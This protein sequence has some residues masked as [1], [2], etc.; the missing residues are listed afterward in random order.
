MLV[1]RLLRRP[2]AILAAWAWRWRWRTAAQ[3]WSLTS[4]RG[5]A[6]VLFWSQ[7]MLDIE[8]FPFQS[9]SVMWCGGGCGL[10]WSWGTHTNPVGCKRQGP[11][12]RRSFRNAE[13]WD[14]CL[15]HFYGWWWIS[16]T[17]FW[18]LLTWYCWC[19]FMGKCSSFEPN[20]GHSGK[21]YPQSP[22]AKA[23]R[24]K[25]NWVAETD[26]GRFTRF[27][28]RLVGRWFC[29]GFDH[30]KNMDPQWR[31]IYF[32]ES[33][34]TVDE[35]KWTQVVRGVPIYLIAKVIRTRCFQSLALL[36]V[37]EN[38]LAMF[39]ASTLVERPASRDTSGLGGLPCQGQ[40]VMPTFEF[41]CLVTRYVSWALLFD[42]DKKAWRRW[43]CGTKQELMQNYPAALWIFVARCCSEQLFVFRAFLRKE[44]LHSL[45]RRRFLGLFLGKRVI[46]R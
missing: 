30:V 16:P 7:D 26:G 2:Y 43:Q 1:P 33:E 45:E 36:E 27:L 42:K 23:C 20:G 41:W 4:S 44:Y 11:C 3:G 39:V 9:L 32:F 37:E 17:H 34:I 6:R 5:V 24:A 31:M 29:L 12:R 8:K 21:E 22:I 46:T 35:G 14:S 10:R 25:Y 19:F 15:G 18:H 40:C 28:D 13:W 38:G